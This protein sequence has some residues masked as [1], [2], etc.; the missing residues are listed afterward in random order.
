MLLEIVS[1]KFAILQWMTSMMIFRIAMIFVF[2]GKIY[3]FLAPSKAEAEAEALDYVLCLLGYVM[4]RQINTFFLNK[5]TETNTPIYNS[6]HSNQI[7]CLATK[8][9][10]DISE[11]ITICVR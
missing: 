8:G 4:S 2:S 5:K 3:H 9:N 11:N 7:E 1:V 6:K 10:F